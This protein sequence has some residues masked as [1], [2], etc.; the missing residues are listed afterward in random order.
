M[1]DLFST[2]DKSFVYCTFRK[3][4]FL[5]NFVSLSVSGVAHIIDFGKTA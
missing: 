5:C 4:V 1:I 2:K 3:I